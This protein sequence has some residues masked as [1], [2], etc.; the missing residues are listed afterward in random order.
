MQPD[1][2]MEIFRILAAILHL[3]NVAIHASGRSSE[4]SFVDVR[5]VS[6]FLPDSAPASVAKA[7]RTVCVLAGGRPLSGCLLQ[8]VGSGGATDGSLVVSP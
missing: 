2:Q 5:E 4:R 3:G 8:A 6:R 7:N 1:Q